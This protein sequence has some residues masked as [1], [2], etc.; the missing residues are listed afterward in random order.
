LI[1]SDFAKML[2]PFCSN[3][4][5][6]SDFVI[7]LFDKIMEE[8]TSDK[9]IEDASNGEYNP[10][11]KLNIR[12]LERNYSGSLQLGKPNVRKVI[13]RLDKGK[14]EDYIGDL[15]IDTI[16]LLKE[17]LKRQGH[18]IPDND[19][20]TMCANIFTDLLN[21]AIIP[22]TTIEIPST[23][24]VNRNHSLNT[25]SIPDT[26][27]YL[28]METKGSCPS[29]GTSLVSNKNHSSLGKYEITDLVPE[30]IY[31][32]V[33][34]ESDEINSFVASLQGNRGKIALCLECSNKYKANTTKDECIKLIDTKEKLYRNYKASE[35]L[36]K[37]YLEEEIEFILRKIAGATQDQLSDTLNLN[38]VRVKNKIPEDNFPLI[39]KTQGYVVQYFK[40]IRTI[41]TQLE[42]EGKLNFDDVALDVHRSFG[43]LQKQGLSQ[44]EIYDSLVTWFGQKAN[45]KRPVAC[46][47]IVAFFIQNCEVF[48]AITQ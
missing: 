39:F 17:A 25:G 34:D 47:I 4:M 5:R 6:A 43:K 20:P 48:H 2:Y 18:D 41:F 8:P 36:E 15:T 46:E 9:D 30:S 44:D 45:V 33:I 10:F 24:L 7:V 35:V 21:D 14:F 38:A 11:A 28:L 29:C 13:A 32:D 19:V 42:R 40:F 12:T 31:N 27:L 26:D 23:S 16:S 37:M 1:F 22:T 3:G